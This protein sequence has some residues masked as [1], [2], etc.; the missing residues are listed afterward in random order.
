MTAATTPEEEKELRVERGRLLNA[1]NSLHTQ[2]RL[3][4]QEL[5]E[6]RLLM[7]HV[8]KKQNDLER[9]LTPVEI[10]PPKTP[11]T[12]T[13]KSPQRA[14]SPEELKSFLKTLSPSELEELR[15]TLPMK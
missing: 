1:Y 3:L 2:E 10:V 13:R 14:L 15:R 5:A 9:L 8:Q 6:C 11:N 12:K 4:F 7:Q